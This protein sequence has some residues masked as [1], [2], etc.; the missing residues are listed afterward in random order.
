MHD[1]FLVKKLK[2]FKKQIKHFLMHKKY[3]VEEIHTLRVKSRELSSLLNVDSPFYFHVKQIIKASNNI[4]DIDVF[5]EV[6]LP[7]LPK[8]FR[9]LLDLKSIKQS[10]KKKR[11]KRI[12]QLYTYLTSLLIPKSVSIDKAPLPSYSFINIKTPLLDQ[13]ELHRY[14]ISIKKRLY[15]EKNSDHPNKEKIKTLTKTKDLLGTINDNYNGLKRLKRYDIQQELYNQIKDF[16]ENENLNLY[17]K[18]KEIEQ[19]L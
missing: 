7:S 11:E 14:R 8:R 18:F 3:S 12:D 1:E 9:N 5:L 13:K 19:T 17:Q 16:T 6:Y 2:A 4:R 15:K 10:Q